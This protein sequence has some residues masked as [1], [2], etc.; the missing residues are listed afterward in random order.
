MRAALV[1]YSAALQRRSVLWLRKPTVKGIQL[2]PCVGRVPVAADQQGI[3]ESQ[4]LLRT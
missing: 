1:K 4:K 2:V 3:E